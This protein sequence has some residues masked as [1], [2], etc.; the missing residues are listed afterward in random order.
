MSMAP[1]ANAPEE[2]K[3]RSRG[4]QDPQDKP[5]G[6]Q[7][8][9]AMMALAL[10]LIAVS[11]LG[12]VWLANRGNETREVIMVAEHVPFG[13]P[14]EATDL[15]MRAFP[16]EV[17]GIETVPYSQLDQIVGTL[18]QRDLAPNTL[19]TPDAFAGEV[20]LEDGRVIIG[21]TVT[22]DRV[23]AVELKAGAEVTLVETPGQQG[24]EIETGQP[25]SATF[26]SQDTIEG[27]GEVRL[28]LDVAAT[29]AAAIAARASVDRLYVIYGQTSA[30]A[31]G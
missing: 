24:T 29:Q 30:G 5:V 3:K 16:V 6:K 28:T 10:M 12:G 14:I 1:E 7:R 31:D 26:I 21:V 11:A 18:A 15:Q 13:Q 9:P 17:T 22:P 25:F 19:L 23:P 20:K 8:R 27:T 4:T 2:S